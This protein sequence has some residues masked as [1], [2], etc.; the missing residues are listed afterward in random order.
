MNKV[1]GKSVRGTHI[2]WWQCKNQFLNVHYLC[3]VLFFI[4]ENTSMRLIYNTIHQFISDFSF[5]EKEEDFWNKD[6]FIFQWNKMYS[7]HT[8]HCTYIHSIRRKKI[9]FNQMFSS[10][11]KYVCWSIEL[12]VKDERNPLQ[13]MS[14]TFY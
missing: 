2:V 7:W 1:C 6:D 12:W 14:Y 5:N 8:M 13:K 3:V 9:I 11:I 10:V 4:I